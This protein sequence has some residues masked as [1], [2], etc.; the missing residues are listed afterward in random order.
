MFSRRT[1]TRGVTAISGTALLAMSLAACSGGLGGSSSGGGSSD[2][3]SGKLSGPVT[4][5]LLAGGNDPVATATSK[6]YAEGFHKANPQITVKVDTRPGG[7]D[8][9]NLIKTRLSTGEMD[10]VFLY[11]SGSLF[12][13]LRAD[14]TLQPLTNEPWVKNISDDFKKTVSTPK[15]VYGAPNGTTF[16]GGVMYNKKV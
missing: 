16:A 1:A 5:K 10:D 3:S 7:T 6:A 9:D 13:A 11:N 8:G 4:I 14:T 12:Q 2:T 15:G